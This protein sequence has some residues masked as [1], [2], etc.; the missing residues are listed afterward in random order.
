MHF[1]TQCQ[2]AASCKNCEKSFEE[3]EILQ[4][5]FEISHKKDDSIG[6]PVTKCK[7]KSKSVNFL[8]MHIGVDHHDLVRKKLS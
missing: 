6:C 4:E 2:I 3:E 1:A 8:V 5:H 7:F